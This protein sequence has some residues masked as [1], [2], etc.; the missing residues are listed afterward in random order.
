MYKEIIEELYLGTGSGLV[1]AQTS[2]NGEQS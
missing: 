2:S 1:F